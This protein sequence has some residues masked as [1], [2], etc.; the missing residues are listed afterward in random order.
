MKKSIIILII[1]L[2]M[3]SL[4]G[5][6]PIR[7]LDNYYVDQHEDGYS[8]L[9]KNEKGTVE[10]IVA[11]G[12]E[13]QPLAIAK[14]RICFVEEGKLVSVDL[15]GEN[16]Q[17]LLIDGLP[18]DA[19]VT[20]MDETY[21]YCLTGPTARTCWEV[22]LDLHAY[23]QGPVPRKYRSVDYAA[24]LQAIRTQVAASEDR[25]RVR[26]ARV[27]MDGFGT[28]IA[29]TLEVLSHSGKISGMEFWNRGTVTVSLPI[30]S[31][32]VDYRDHHMPLSLAD[33]T[34]E[35]TVTLEQFLTALE[36]ADT[37]EVAS[38]HAFGTGNGYVLAYLQ[39]EYDALRSE[40]TAW[41]TVSG[42]ESSAEAQGPFFVLGQW[43]GTVPMLTDS[44]GLE[45]GSLY[46][47]HW[48]S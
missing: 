27:E 30:G 42:G 38:Q 3:L 40:F 15:E 47:L 33:W 19:H 2:L 28:P 35:E 29:M 41:L 8:V 45:V 39:E 48:E 24:L 1:F 34:V 5:C 16:R 17:E 14:G 22:Y 36:T 21:L 6:E 7:S 32:E 23:S 25:I 4:V 10:Q 12:A 46:A 31:V 13:P 43:G 26:S 37:A 18:S 11:L 9:Y 20:Y 44:K